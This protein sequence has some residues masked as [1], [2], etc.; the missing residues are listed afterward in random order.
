MD[1]QVRGEVMSKILI[2]IL[3]IL[4]RK[5]MKLSHISMHSIML[6][7]NFVVSQQKCIIALEII[8]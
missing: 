6:N 2:R 4:K 7:I 8:I 5:Q 3:A 1:H